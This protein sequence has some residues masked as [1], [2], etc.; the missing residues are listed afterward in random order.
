MAQTLLPGLLE[1][2]KKNYRQVLPIN[3]FEI[4]KVYTKDEQ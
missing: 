3:I 1:I 4:G 2:A